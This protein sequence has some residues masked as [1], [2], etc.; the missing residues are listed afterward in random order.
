M[1]LEKPQW[2]RE[3]IELYKKLYY[4]TD[5][6]KLSDKEKAF[7]HDMSIMEQYACGLDGGRD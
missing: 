3:D 7:C 5:Y 1:S 6:D 4:C 2:K